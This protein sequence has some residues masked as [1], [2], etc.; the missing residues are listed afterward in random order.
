ME[1]DS[2]KKDIEIIKKFKQG[3]ESA[4]DE[5]VKKYRERIY[6]LALSITHNHLDADDL[7]QEIFVKLYF[8]INKFDEKSTFYTWFYRVSVNHI[9]K[10]LKK[11]DHFDKNND[12]E[13]MKNKTIDF[14]TP[15]VE[16]ENKE[17]ASLLER[18][19]DSLPPIQRI[20]VV[21]SKLEGYSH[22]EIA[23]ILGC[24]VP[25]VRWNLFVSLRKLKKIL[26]N[27]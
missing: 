5:I 13:Y 9:L 22:K 2:N 19:L 14:K 3:D 16:I 1:N 23:S 15:E 27:N 25:T 26:Q 4:F 18:A 11:R 21:L 17:F 20:I 6:R 8:S 10:Y 7:S 12:F 24:A